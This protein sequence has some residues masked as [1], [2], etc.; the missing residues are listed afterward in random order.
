MYT[1]T[2]IVYTYCTE[3]YIVFIPHQHLLHTGAFPAIGDTDITKMQIHCG[4]WIVARKEQDYITLHSLES[5]WAWW[6]ANILSEAY[7]KKIHSF[8]IQCPMSW[9]FHISKLCVSQTSYYEENTLTLSSPSYN[10]IC[11]CI[12]S[13]KESIKEAAVIF[14]MLMY[15]K[16]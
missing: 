8:F 10:I 1:P 12:L 9:K 13:L 4:L 15:I 3:Y 5:V 11:A 2:L 7:W 6:H 16:T 14:C